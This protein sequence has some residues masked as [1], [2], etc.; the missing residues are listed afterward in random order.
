MPNTPSPLCR[1]IVPVYRTLTPAEW[2]IAAHNLSRLR[3]YPICLVGQDTRATELSQDAKRAANATGASVSVE[4]F[5]DS[6][7]LSIEGY[8][9]LLTSRGFYERFS[10]ADYILICQ[11]DCIIIGEDLSEWMAAGY[12]FVGAP[13]F[14]GFGNPEQPL[15]FTG[16]LNGGLSLRCVQDALSALDSL[17]RLPRNG[18]SRALR[19]IGALKLAHRLTGNPVIVDQP[20]LNEDMFWTDI[21]AQ[22]SEDFKIPLPSIAA[23]FA[24]EA[25]PRYLFELTGSL[26]FGCHAYERYDPE[27]WEE[28]LPSEMSK[29]VKDH[30]RE[31]G[32]T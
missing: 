13:V 8:S 1:V 30:V 3:G 12:S 27:Y 11:H 21:V 19:R 2:A 26:P 17:V 5:A 16:A 9:S 6:F 10:D 23:R 32:P 28:I 24:F 22:S 15:R 20:G 31:A 4:T 25:C 18:I 7:F 14:V 29:L